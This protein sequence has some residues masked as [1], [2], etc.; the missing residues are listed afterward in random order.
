MIHRPAERDLFM[1]KL[2]VSAL[3]TLVGLL[4]VTSCSS[5][6]S[7]N[8]TPGPTISSSA[9][10]SSG[11]TN[12]PSSPSTPTVSSSATAPAGSSGL[13]EQSATAALI[14]LTELGGGGF[15]KGTFDSTATPGPC[16]SATAPTIE[17][18]VPSQV[19][20]G[21]DYDVSNK[22]AV[23]EQITSYRDA[24]T[25]E[26]ALEYGAKGLDCKSGSSKSASGT[27]TKV[28][29]AASPNNPSTVY[30]GV[31]VDKVEG[32]SLETTSVQ[33]GLVAARIGANLVTLQFASLKGATLTG[34]RSSTDI[35]SDALKKVK[36]AA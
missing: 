25:A 15:T 19:R 6:I 7:G 17:D 22:A 5:S 35:V 26:H 29:I 16:Q 28:T 1:S 13:D 14:T 31:T 9:G 30:N 2:R 33:Y 24:D 3:S 12:F 20:V 34:V 8:P 11:P 4:T 18:V 23:Q 32:W 27:P 21:V 10:S 36:D